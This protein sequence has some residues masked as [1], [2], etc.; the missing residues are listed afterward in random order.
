MT[1]LSTR[2]RAFFILIIICVSG[3]YAD[4]PRWPVDG[5]IDLSSSFCEFRPGH[6]HGGVDIRTGG[7]EGREVLAPADGYVWRIRYSYGGYGKALYLKDHDG[8]MYVFGHLSRLD[9]SLERLVHAH[10]YAAKRYYLDLYFPPDSLPVTA[11]EVIAYSGQTGYGGPHIHFE[12]RTS[13]NKPLNPLTNGFAL[14]DNF[15]PVIR[16]MQ[17]VYRDSTSVFPNGKRRQVIPVRFDRD[18]NRYVVDSV[19][20]VQGDVGFAVKAFDQ[21]R[22]NGPSLNLYRVRLFIDDYLY[23]ENTFEQYDYAETGMVD[24]LFDYYMLMQDWDDWHVLFDRPGKKFSGSTSYHADRGGF[25]GST[26]YSYGM[27]TAR[28]ETYDAAGNRSDLE[29][30]FMFAP[31]GTF[32]TPRWAG[33]STLYLTACPDLEY[34]DIKRVIVSGYNGA[35]GWKHFDPSSI[36]ARGRNNYVVHVP[37]GR[38][39]WQKL[40]ISVAGVSGWYKDDLYLSMASPRDMS[41]DIDYRLEGRGVRFTVTTRDRLAPIPR[42][43]LV[44]EDGY[45]CHVPV[46]AVSP[47]TYAAFY[48]ADHIATR[49]IRCYV[50]T[51]HSVTPIA[52]R[53]VNLLAVGVGLKPL[54]YSVDKI[55]TVTADAGC[56]YA[57]I[58]IEAYRDNR[59]FPRKADRIGGVYVLGPETLPLAGDVIV[60]FRGDFTANDTQV[61]VYRLNDDNEWS[62]LETTREQGR[63]SA[64]TS[65]MGTYAV[66]RD[67]EAPRVKNISPGRNRSIASVYPEIHCM[68]SDKLSGIEDDDDVAVYID[69]EWAIPEY[70]PET[71]V[72]KTVAPVK[73]TDGR[74]EITFIV[75]DRAGNS[76]TVTSEFVVDTNKK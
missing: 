38:R 3:A 9:N 55:F 68:V 69:G 42:L 28:V 54:R 1:I 26:R 74:H 37:P 52:S 4:S 58:L 67:T 33:D 18:R 60:S 8:H 48:R 46:T 51:E 14:N 63:L 47:R 25:S 19:Y 20:L 30:R 16:E 62:P 17:M 70:D 57:P 71:E 15:P 49:I 34:I 32:F 76:R 29:F 65:L 44:Y 13:D 6:F 72:L 43:E 73:L 66:L 61:A 59:R 64:R 23:Y 35:G 40:R 36:E 27:H 2:T 21:I 45:T 50:Y 12:K 41:Y 24:L 75:S 53:D 39:D 10:Q 22:H 31:S 5:E 7:R 11:G 56:T